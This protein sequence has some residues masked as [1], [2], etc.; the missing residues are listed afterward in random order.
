MDCLD[1][2]QKRR[3]VLEA[4]LAGRAEC[5]PPNTLILHPG[6]D[7]GQMMFCLRKD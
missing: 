6:N 5:D 4:R 7:I 3:N 2:R 1:R